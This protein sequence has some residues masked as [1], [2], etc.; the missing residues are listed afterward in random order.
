MTLRGRRLHRR[1]RSWYVLVL[2]CVLG[3]SEHCRCVFVHG[4]S[5]RCFLA[6]LELSCLGHFRACLVDFGL[7]HTS[8]SSSCSLFIPSSPPFV[9]L[10]RYVDLRL[11]R[12][13]LC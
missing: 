7:L 3:L 9:P 8:S 12:P 13:T 4:C 11:R 1:R 10:L 5:E 2:V 6:S